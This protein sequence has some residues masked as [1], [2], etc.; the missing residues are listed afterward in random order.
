MY[1][2]YTALLT[3]KNESLIKLDTIRKPIIE[4]LALTGVNEQ[5]S[6]TA[7][8][9]AVQEKFKA[10]KSELQG[11]LDAEIKKRETVEAALLEQSKAAIASSN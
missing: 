6:D 10:E 4:A 2:Q 7:V 8:I 9:A 5:S 3:P 11:K 1:Y